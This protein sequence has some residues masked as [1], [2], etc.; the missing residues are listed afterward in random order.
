MPA[1][2]GFYK[3]Q[4]GIYDGIKGAGILHNAKEFHGENE[5]HRVGGHNLGPRYNILDERRCSGANVVAQCQLG[6]GAGNDGNK[7]KDNGRVHLF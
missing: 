1:R 6:D 4:N 7:N 5:H 2:I 3:F